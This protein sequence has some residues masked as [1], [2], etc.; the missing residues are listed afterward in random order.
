VNPAHTDG[1]VLVA[2]KAQRELLV[3]AVSNGEARHAA[4]YPILA[5]SGGPGPKRREGDRQVPEGVY[6]I[7]FLNP[8]SRFRLSLRVDYPNESD[9]AAAALEGRELRSLGGDIMIHGGAASV[10]CV[11]IGDP[12]IEEVFWLVARVG[13]ENTEVLLAPGRDPVTFGTASTPAWLTER[14]TMLDSR[15]RELGVHAGR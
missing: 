1:V 13:K 9:R 3:F 15:F 14:Y 6:R 2:L 4:N 10:G 12:A 11:A 5:A 7:E 8:N